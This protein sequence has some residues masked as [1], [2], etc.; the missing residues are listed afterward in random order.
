LEEGTHIQ[1]KFLIQQTAEGKFCVNGG[2]SPLFD[3]VPQLVLY[4]GQSREY[5][6]WIPYIN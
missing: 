2:L 5:Q 6:I 3:S 1:R 4:M